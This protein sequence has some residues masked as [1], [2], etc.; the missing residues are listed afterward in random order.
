MAGA[1][2]LQVQVALYD[3]AE[4]G[5]QVVPAGGGVF[6]KTVTFR[7]GIFEVVFT[8]D[9]LSKLDYF[10]NDYYLNVKVNAG[11]AWREFAPRPRLASS[12]YA[13]MA[14]NLKG[15]PVYARGTPAIRMGAPKSFGL[16]EGRVGGLNFGVSGYGKFE[17]FG[18]RDN[19][20]RVRLGTMEV[21][22]ALGYIMPYFGIYFGIYSSTGIIDPRQRQ[23]T[24]HPYHWYSIENAQGIQ[25]RGTGTGMWAVSTS[26]TTAAVVAENSNSV[27]RGSAFV[28]GSGAIEIN[29]MV[30]SPVGVVVCSNPRPTANGW[31]VTNSLAKNDSLILV[32]VQNLIEEKVWVSGRYNGY[33][34]IYRERASTLEVEPA[35]NVGYLIIN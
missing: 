5:A 10:N 6:E 17:S 32:E 24:F 29:T 16:L 3:A 14:N 25:A 9:L 13:F 19:G 7:D 26:P 11:G 20:A 31:K 4:G 28:A 15:G 12:P 22:S 33:F 23:A 21:Y 1:K 30:P 34:Y 2:D 18:T 8:N 27:R 35:L